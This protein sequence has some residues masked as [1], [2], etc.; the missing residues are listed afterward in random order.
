MCCFYAWDGLK[1]QILFC[2]WEQKDVPN[3]NSM[4]SSWN[5][6][7][8]DFLIT[9]GVWNMTSIQELFLLDPPFS[10]AGLWISRTCRKDRFQA[11]HQEIVKMKSIPDQSTNLYGQSSKEDI[12][13]IKTK[14]L[15]QQWDFKSDRL[16][17]GSV[18]RPIHG[19]W[20]RH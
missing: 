7:R 15:P 10:Q 5:A 12:V 6:D 13:Q 19:Y 8:A 4:R 9:S 16:F 14:T 20:N 3:R 11:I 1:W 2:Q 18:I 17:F